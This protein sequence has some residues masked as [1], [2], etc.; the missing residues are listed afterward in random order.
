MCVPLV[1]M[2]L[3][4]LLSSIACNAPDLHGCC[5]QINR[6]RVEANKAHERILRDVWQMYRKCTAN[7]A[8]E[9]D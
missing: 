9:S 1:R 6:L 5:T 3:I 8:A 7:C 4:P 2:Y